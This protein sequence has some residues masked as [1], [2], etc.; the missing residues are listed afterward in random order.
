M[1]PQIALEISIGKG[2][3]SIQFGQDEQQIINLLGRPDKIY[4]SAG[5][6]RLQYFDLLI[7]VAIEFEYENKFGWLEVQNPDATLFGQ[8]LIGASVEKV[9]SVVSTEIADRPKHDD[10]G[11]LET[12]FYENQWLELQ[13]AMNRLISINIGVLFIDDNRPDWP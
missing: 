2:V 3:G 7:E 4:E 6:K 13:F 8:K 12:Y 1:I 11:H 5:S 9:L 10:Y